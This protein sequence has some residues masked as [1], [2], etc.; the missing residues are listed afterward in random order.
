MPDDY[1]D[2]PHHTQ[3]AAYFDA[4]VDHFGLREKITFETG[5]ERAE[6]R[7]DGGWRVHARERRGARL[8][9]AAG[10]QRP[11]LGPALARAGVPGR[12]RASRAC[13][14]TRTTTSATTRR[15]SRGK[16]VVVLGMGNSAMDIAVEATQNAERVFLA[17]RRGAWIVPEVRL[18]PPARPVRHRAA[19][20]ARGPPALHGRLTLRAAVG[21]HGALRAA[22]ARP[23]PARGAPDDLGHDPHPAH[24]RRHHAEAEHRAADRATRV[25]FADGSE[26]EADVVVYGTGYKVSFPFFDPG[27]RLRARQ[28][29]AAVQARLPPRPARPVLHRAAAAARRDDAARRGAVGVDLRPPDGPLRAAAAAASCSPTSRAS[30]RRCAAATS[31][32]SATRCRSTTTTTCSS[33]SASASAARS[34]CEPARGDQGGQPRGDPRRRPRR[35]HR[36][37]LRG[38]RRAR[39]RSAA[40]TS[41][42]ARST[43]TST[44]RTPSSRA[45]LEEAGAE[46]RRQVREA[47]LAAATARASS[48]RA[49]ARSSPSSPPTRRRS[50]SW[51]ATPR[52]SCP[53]RSTSCAR[54]SRGGSRTASTSTTRRTRWSPSGCR[55]A[56]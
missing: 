12:G 24:P 15:C 20:P 34:G 11:P 31:P 8:P 47:R 28:R 27:A 42:R 19:D 53:R 1:P 4:Y 9:R 48:P 36:A 29:P 2:F 32:P 21:G 56:R 25:V 13:R 46:A 3:V 26:E 50:P 52:R 44:A 17:A 40:R 16:R 54:T 41:P 51:S 7:R 10:R 18:R 45:V 55:S 37:R 23:P 5:V 14:C 6:P 22:E 38:R 30:A 33:S 43:T 35:L 49:S 39:R